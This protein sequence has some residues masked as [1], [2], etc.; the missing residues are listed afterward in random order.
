MKNFLNFLKSTGVVLWIVLLALWV[1]ISVVEVYRIPETGMMP[2]LM[3]GDRVFAGKL[4]Y[5]LR[6]PFIKSFVARW[7]RPQRGDVI[8][9]RSPFDKSSLSVRRVV[10]LPGDR[11]F[12]EH[13][14]LYI[15][16]H[17]II[18]KNPGKRKKDLSWI[19][20]KDFFD[21]G[22]GM[23]K[24][25]FVHKEEHLFTR[26]YSVLLKKKKLGYL[27]FGP[28]LIA[29]G[30]YFVLGDHRDFTQ[31]SRTWPAQ[32]GR[33]RGQ[34]VFFRKK[35]GPPVSIPRGTVVSRSHPQ[36]PEYFETLKTVVLRG[37]QVEV[38]VQAQKK[39]VSGNV[40]AYQINRIESAGL[41]SL[42]VHNSF[43]MQ[44]GQSKNLVAEGD[45]LGKL[46]RVWFSCEDGFWFADFICDFR[47]LRW[48]R[49]LRKIHR[50]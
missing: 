32:L 50:D 21:T 43:D 48:G 29:E 44:G 16:E 28:Y 34:V 25:D 17:K 2:T 7:S 45:I 6:L 41:S 24:S 47:S 9:F 22:R 12:F 23:G 46:W 38:D 27:I 19:K 49:S 10:G 26:S 39:G 5:G 4:A 14:N 1:R 20:D 18:K 35:P 13:G 11:V 15:N 37:L 31:D 36:L 8:V 42:S 30:H 33:A 3:E 40:K